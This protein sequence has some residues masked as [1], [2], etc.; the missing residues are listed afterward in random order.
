MA[1]VGVWRL[2]R[3]T[4]DWGLGIGVAGTGCVCSGLGD[5]RD[6]GIGKFLPK[7]NACLEPQSLIPNPVWHAW[8][9]QT[10]GSRQPAA[11]TIPRSVRPGPPAAD[12]YPAPPA[13]HR[14]KLKFDRPCERWRSDARS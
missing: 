11:R 1:E 10:T 3:L 8:A 12:A 4:R 13:R 14:P 7:R 9:G 6:L 5:K 2:R